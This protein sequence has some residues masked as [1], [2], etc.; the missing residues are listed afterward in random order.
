M[1]KKYYDKLLHITGSF[2]ALIWLARMVPVL[3]ALL[4]VVSLCVLKT[5][6]N[7]KSDSAY[8]PYR[9]WIANFI[10]IGLW[11]LYETIFAT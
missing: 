6:W 7:Y 5:I 11:R 4:I 2:M 10:G 3:F 1:L 9:D 8:K